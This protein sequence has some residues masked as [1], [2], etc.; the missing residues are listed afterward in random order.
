[1]PDCG[2]KCR[3]DAGWHVGHGFDIADL[4]DE[5]SLRRAGWVKSGTG[6]SLPLRSPSIDGDASQSPPAASNAPIEG[7]TPGGVGGD[8]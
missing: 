5:D 6:W 2:P 4:I 1:M 3:P 7:I 8:S